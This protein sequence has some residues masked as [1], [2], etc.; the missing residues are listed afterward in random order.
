MTE[1]LPRH[2]TTRRTGSAGIGLF[3]KEP[4]AAAKEIWGLKKPWAAALDSQH[5]QDT[6]SNCFLWLPDQGESESESRGQS[7][8]SLDQT[9]QIDR[10]QASLKQC[11]GCKVVRYCC[12]VGGAL[13]AR[14][15]STH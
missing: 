2:L 3:T 11:L 1:T 6:C 9:S 14:N 13:H 4:F 15:I 7:E 10:I 5:L 12:K 8:S